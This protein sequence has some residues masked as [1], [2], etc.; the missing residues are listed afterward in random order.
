MAPRLSLWLF[1]SMLA[2][3][4]AVEKALTLLRF[5]QRSNSK[6][7]AHGFRIITERTQEATAGAATELTKDN[8]YA[9]VALCTVEEI[10][11][12]SA[13]K[14]TTVMAVICKVVAPSKTRQHTA[15]LYIEAM[16]PVKKDD[17]ASSRGMMRKLQ[18]IF[19]G[20]ICR[21]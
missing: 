14:D 7:H 8:C 2:D 11:D 20:T 17:I 4:R 16:E 18:H 13:A 3:G 5:T 21:P 19:E 6:Q 9:T 15:D 10:P 1:Y 12:F